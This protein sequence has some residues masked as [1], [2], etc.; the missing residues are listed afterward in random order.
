MLSFHDNI[1]RLPPTQLHLLYIQNQSNDNE[2]FITTIPPNVIEAQLTTVS[3][4]VNKNLFKQFV[5]IGMKF[6]FTFYFPLIVGH[7]CNLIEVMWYS[8]CFRWNNVF[9]FNFEYFATHRNNFLTQHCSNYCDWA[10]CCKFYASRTNEIADI[11]S[12]LLWK[13]PTKIL[14]TYRPQYNYVPNMVLNL[15][16]YPTTK[17]NTWDLN[18]A[19]K[20]Y[21]HQK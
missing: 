8:L 14:S 2:I 13:S 6:L 10:E 7:Q 3:Y 21:I 5:D 4:F 1:T 15:I 9:L 11:S 20:K 16:L 17:W 18:F 19:K 12:K